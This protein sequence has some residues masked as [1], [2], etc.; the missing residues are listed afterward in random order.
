MSKIHY[1]AVMALSRPAR[2][3]TRR[4]GSMGAR[5]RAGYIRVLA[6]ALI[7]ALV[8]SACQGMTRPGDPALSQAPSARATSSAEAC[9]LRRLM[10]IQLEL[11]D[12]Y[13]RR[14]R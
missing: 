6:W 5:S 9:S 11:D 13:P 10:C 1:L 7:A 14:D 4:R 3:S 12:L 2:V 8:L